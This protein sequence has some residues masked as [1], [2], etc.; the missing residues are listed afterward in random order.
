MKQQTLNSTA[1]NEP[2]EIFSSKESSSYR[3]EIVCIVAVVKGVKC[4]HFTSG[5]ISGINSNLWFPVMN[6]DLFKTIEDIMVINSL[7]NNVTAVEIIMRNNDT[8]S[9]YNVIFNALPVDDI[10]NESVESRLQR[11]PN[12]MELTC[13]IEDF[14]ASLGVTIDE[15]KTYAQH[16]ADFESESKEEY[17]DLIYLLHIAHKRYIELEA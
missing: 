10:K 6:G 5:I 17:S 15:T 7:C 4:V 2:K 1:A 16:A 12:S 13:I 3:K 11:A 9:D 8:S 14:C